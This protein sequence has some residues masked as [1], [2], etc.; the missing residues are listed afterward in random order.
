MCSGKVSG[1]KWGRLLDYRRL[2]VADEEEDEKR[3]R[4]T[5]E[6][7]AG[8]EEEEDAKRL[9]WR[10]REVRRWAETELILPRAV[11]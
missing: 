8:A 1:C 2:T 5:A 7:G 10:L 3:R 11:G 9:G 4:E 6:E